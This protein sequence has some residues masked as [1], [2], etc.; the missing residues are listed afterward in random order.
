MGGLVESAIRNSVG[1][2]VDRDER[3]AR[4]VLANEPRIDAM[5][6]EIDDAALVLLARNQPMAG[7][8]RRLAATIKMKT[9]LERIG[10][11][12]SHIAE[13]ALS[14]M[15]LP[16]PELA[17]IPLLARLSA[18]MV[19]DSLDALVRHDSDLA[20]HVLL[21]DD[22][23][24]QLRDKLYRSLIRSIE[25]DPSATV[26]SL[27]LLFVVCHLERIADHATNIGEDVLFCLRGV[28]VRHHSSVLTVSPA[29]SRSR[30]D[31][32]DQ[33]KA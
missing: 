27:H 2:L 28:D 29:A 20:E 33:F 26:P 3:L 16:Q 21:A 24:D 8:M 1:A 31:E 19:H 7:D 9:D 25:K 22:E 18:A 32:P 14:L 30:R 10:D 13:R 5:E 12:A 11:L 23:V 15:Q 6:I 17:E 4:E